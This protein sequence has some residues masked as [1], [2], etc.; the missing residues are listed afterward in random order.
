MNVKDKYYI[1]S[2]ENFRCRKNDHKYNCYNIKSSKYNRKVYKYIRENCDDWSEVSFNII[3][4]YDDIS[5]DFKEEIEDYYIEYFNNNLNMIRAKTNKKIR[6]QPSNKKIKCECG[7]YIQKCKLKEHLRTK[8]H[9][10]L[11]NAFM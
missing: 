3:D 7:R 1:G 8:I 2:T 10:K 9:N 4:I 6:Y 11:M 5:K